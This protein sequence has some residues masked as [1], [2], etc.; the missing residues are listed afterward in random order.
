M[1]RDLD[2]IRKRSD[3]FLFDKTNQEVNQP[4]KYV[5]NLNLKKQKNSQYSSNRKDRPSFSINQSLFYSDKK[6][7]PKI[8]K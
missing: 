8:D 6:A 7:E 4:T 2:C 1:M 3:S 5:V